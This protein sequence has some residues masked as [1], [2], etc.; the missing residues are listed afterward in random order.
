MAVPM[1]PEKIV[2]CTGFRVITIYTEAGHFGYFLLAT[3]ATVH[4]L[5]P[6][7]LLHMQQPQQGLLAVVVITCIPSSWYKSI[8]VRLQ[9]SFTQ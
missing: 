1:S 2:Y 9:E 6:I 3:V 7:N 4:Y 5:H 8:S